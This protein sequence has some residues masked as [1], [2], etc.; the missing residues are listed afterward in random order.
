MKYNEIQDIIFKGKQNIQ[1]P[2]VENYLRKYEGKTIIVKE[3]GDGIGMIHFSL[4]VFMNKGV[5]N[6]D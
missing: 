1:W 4:F 6:I 5:K 3:T 2:D